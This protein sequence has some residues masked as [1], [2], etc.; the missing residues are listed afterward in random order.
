[1]AEMLAAGSDSVQGRADFTYPPFEAHRHQIRLVRLDPEQ[2]SPHVSCM[3]RTFS[4]DDAP[5]YE[6]L[7]Y[8]WG[9]YSEQ[10]Y[11]VIVNDQLFYVWPNLHDALQRLRGSFDERWLWI[12]KLCINMNDIHEHSVQ[13]TLMRRIF[14]R[15]KRVIVW[16]CEQSMEDDDTGELLKDSVAYKRNDSSTSIP[17]LTRRPTEPQV[18]QSSEITSVLPWDMDTKIA[19]TANPLQLGKEYA[20][21]LRN[22]WFTRVWTLQEYVLARAVVF[23]FKRHSIAAPDLISQ[24]NVLVGRLSTYQ[25]AST[26]EQGELDAIKN[27]LRGFR[28]F[29]WVKSEWKQHMDDIVVFGRIVAT[30]QELQSRVPLDQ[31]YGLLAL[32]PESLREQLRPDYRLTLD[33]L[34]LQLAQIVSLKE[35]VESVLEN[36]SQKYLLPPQGALA[37]NW[38]LEWVDELSLQVSYI[39]QESS[40]GSSI[41]QHVV[42]ECLDILAIERRP[43]TT[44]IGLSM[45]EKAI[46]AE[47]LRSSIGTLLLVLSDR[48]PIDGSGTIKSY[49]QPDTGADTALYP[50]DDQFSDSGYSSASSTAEQTSLVADAIAEHLLS[51]KS[52]QRLISA[53][54]GIERRHDVLERHLRPCIRQLGKELVKAASESIELT[55]ARELEKHAPFIARALVNRIRMAGLPE[56]PAVKAMRSSKIQK[57]LDEQISRGKTQLHDVFRTSSQHL[58]PSSHDNDRNDTDQPSFAPNSVPQQQLPKSAL[59]KVI[60]FITSDSAFFPFLYL[61]SQ[62]IYSNPLQ[63]VEAEV[64]HQLADFPNDAQD[65]NS[66]VIWVRWDWGAFLSREG[67]IEESNVDHDRLLHLLVISGNAQSCYATNIETYLAWRWP[68]TST[69]LLDVLFGRGNHG[70]SKLSNP[71]KS[72][73][74]TIVSFPRL[75]VQ[76]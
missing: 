11:R 15:A 41:L 28:Y 74:C 49:T 71:K 16:L 50:V 7:S 39:M 38:M 44:S 3:L 23:L 52:L 48:T 58:T 53:A 6:A 24:V 18:P 25:A 9:S 57:I 65:I 37:P 45:S 27:D 72:S 64:S 14:R 40:E 54:E 4:L 13:V 67:V 61:V 12:D 34:Y 26:E 29:N 46:C 69:Y 75:T 8:N 42:A 2:D 47:S 51:Q 73:V 66:I 59:E 31:V 36:I 22:D 63:L 43:H 1:M 33:E 5:E 35:K 19:V 32:A 10:E 21:H 70:P 55:A 20:S 17:G 60:D 62:M 76:G 30:A 56:D 68:A